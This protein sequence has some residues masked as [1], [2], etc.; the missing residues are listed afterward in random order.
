M[1]AALNSLQTTNYVNTYALASDSKSPN[2]MQVSEEAF[3][4]IC[5]GAV[6]LMVAAVYVLAKTVK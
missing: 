2:Q 5:L 1:N 3:A 4:G 6:L